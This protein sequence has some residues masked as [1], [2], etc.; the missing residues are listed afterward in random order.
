MIFWMHCCIWFANNF[1]RIFLIYF[2]D[3]SITV[4][5]LFSPLYFPLS[6]PSAFSHLSSCPWVIY[7]S[8]LAS[9]L[10]ILFLTFP[11]LF[12]T[13]HLCFLFP[14]P[15]PLFSLTLFPID[16]PP[17]DLH[18]CD[19][20][21]VLVVCFVFVLGSVVNNYEFVVIL[22]FIFLI[23]NFLDKSL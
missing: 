4:V 15:F 5:P 11:Y 6:L 21:P 10:P 19:S 17:C 18:F 3:Y 23:F 1:L 8:S 12:C 7:I 13:Y 9:T 14:V 22:L 20:V 16:N 2:I